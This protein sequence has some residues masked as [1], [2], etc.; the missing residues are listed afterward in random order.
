MNPRTI[1]IKDFHYDLPDEK[2]AVHPLAERHNSKLL[3]YRNHR[4]HDTYY[5]YISD[6][7]PSNS[8]IVFNNT[9]VVQARLIFAKPT[10]GKIEIFCLE[11]G[12]QYPDITVA[13]CQT[14]KVTW[15]CLIGGASKWKRGQI[16]SLE[17]SAK[18]KLLTLQAAFI[19]KLGESFLV[20]LS[21]TP[22]DW[23]FAE[24]LQLTGSIPLPPYLKREAE[25]ADKERYQ[26]V[27]AVKEGSVAAPT[28]GLHF[29]NEVIGSLRKKN[30][31][32]LYLT[33]HVGAGTFKPVKADT[34]EAHDMH[35]EF[36]DVDISSIERLQS[37]LSGPIT[38]VGT[39]SLRTLESLYWVGSFLKENQNQLPTGFELDQWYPYEHN[40]D[41]GA[42]EALDAIKQY[43]QMQNKTRLIVRTRLLVVPGYHFKIVN[44]LVTNFHQPES[45]LLLL[46][47]AFVGEGWRAVYSHALSHDYRFLSYG[48]GCLLFRH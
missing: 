41:L 5:H 35:A 37:A 36:M 22:A 26:T 48:D 11:P 24:V 13:M 47:A 15:N 2:V 27:Y 1:S 6:E 43:L 42:Y 18:G 25:D 29:T 31:Q 17:Q 30:I 19:E 39:T 12:P 40:S 9:R 33:L 28:A 4:I 8:L 21:W 7:L 34:M 38:A 46:V 45:T 44:Q 23:T 14:G 32:P 20:E 16:L 10:G 3:V